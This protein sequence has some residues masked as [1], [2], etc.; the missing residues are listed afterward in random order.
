[1]SELCCLLKA[2]TNAK[3]AA[4]TQVLHGAVVQKEQYNLQYNS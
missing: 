1:M 4:S 3:F 2:V